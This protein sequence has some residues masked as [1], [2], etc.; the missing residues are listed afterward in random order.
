METIVP[1]LHASIPEPLGFGPS[2][3]IRVFLLQ[4]ESGN[5]LIYR[6][7]RLREDAA[8]VNELGGIWRQYLNHHHEAS[9]ECDWVS[10]TFGA[11]L[12]C[13]AADAPMVSEV[14]RVGETFDERHML[15]DDVEIIPTPGHTEGATAYLWDTG[16]H[17]A[18]F[19]GDTI[20]FSRDRWRAALLD[21]VGDR[22]RHIESLN[23]IAGLDFDLVIPGIAP[24]GTPF[25]AHVTRAE[26]RRQIDGIIERLR[27][28]TSG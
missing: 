13:H 18:L 3:E 6:S 5:V 10:G 9:A 28:G 23:L 15:G 11:P 2:L 22:A 17:R 1:G 20:F 16:D 24:A 21:G 14:C 8:R 7:A 19:T 25:F 26:A 4:R 12:H 27:Q